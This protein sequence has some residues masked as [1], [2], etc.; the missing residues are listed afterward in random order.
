MKR[1]LCLIGF[2]ALAAGSGCDTIPRESLNAY[3]SAFNEARSAGESLTA[4]FAAAKAESERRDAAGKPPPA[5][6]AAPEIPLIYVPPA[7]AAPPLTATEARLLAWETIAG[8]NAV[9]AALSA[10]ESVENLRAA[11]G[12]LGET[13]GRIAEA[14]GKSVPGLAPLITL[15]QELAGLIEQAR[16]SAEFASAMAAGAP[17]VRSMLALMT[18]DVKDHYLLRATLANED[19][20]DL[21]DDAK[22]EKA[23]IK[24]AIAELRTT[25]DQFVVLARK[26]DAALAMLQASPRTPIDFAAQ[27]NEMLTVAIALKGH[28]QAYKAARIEGAK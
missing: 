19:L 7:S 13:V 6:A 26:C 20:V 2:V 12:R 10:G 8:Y 17:K 18:D 3:V 5:A 27:A 4:D 11:T 9:L 1:L 22:V 21:D 16:L 28:W 14:G 15:A 25:M 23:R 24:D